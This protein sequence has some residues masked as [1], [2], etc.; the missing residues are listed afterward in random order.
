M[1][2]P[3]CTK[4]GQFTPWMM[5]GLPALFFFSMYIGRVSPGVMASELMR[6]FSVN[7]F[8]LGTLSAFFFYPYVLMQIPVGVLVDRFGVRRLITL[9]LFLSAIATYVFGS[10]TSIGMA[11]AARF[12]F[13]FSASFAFVGSLKLGSNWFPPR[14]LGLLAGLTQ[15]LGMLGAACGQRP[16]AYS[17]D[18]IGWRA[19]EQ[20][21]AIVFLVLGVLVFLLVRDRPSTA[22][23]YT[24]SEPVKGAEL[25]RGFTQVM[26]N[27]QT[28]FNGFFVG[29]LFAPT[30]AFA[31]LWGNEFLKQTY[32]FSLETTSWGVGLIFLGWG[33]GSPLI[34]LLSDRMG[35]R[36]PLMWLSAAL[37][38]ILMLVILYVPDLPQSLLFTL[39]FLFG[40]SNTGVSVG[41]AVASEINPA[42]VAGTSIGISNMW[43]IIIGAGFQPVI[44]W[45]IDFHSSGDIVDGLPVYTAQDYRFAMA[46]LPICLL[47]AFISVFFI[48]ETH[49]VRKEGAFS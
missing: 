24:V 23:D 34:G 27:P 25:F 43:S 13:G 47:L 38:T 19:T 39:L 1:P 35:A 20:S 30:G 31:E 46:S 37:S 12:L 3:K 29:L 32:G 10:T 48:K 41:Y 33:V 2:T 42:A 17:I 8:A 45:L 21:L 11:Q 18:A 6:D 15:M 16:V 26:A 9:M 36:R 40:V 44:G 49:C 28:W 7:A 5:W 14:R 4:V 22:V